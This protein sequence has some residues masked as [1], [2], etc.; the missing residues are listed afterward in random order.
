[1]N[2]IRLQRVILSTT[3]AIVMVAC[4][5]A[6]AKFTGADPVRARLNQL[7]SNQQLAQHAPIAM[8]E[9]RDAVQ[10]AEQSSK[11]Q[12]VAEHLIFMAERKVDIAEAE[13]EQH[14]LESR[15][16]E[17]LAQR[18][19]MQLQARTE[20]SRQATSEANQAKQQA[21]EAQRQ[22][23]EAQADAQLAQQQMNKAELDA[24]KA[25]EEV[26]EME[27]QL[28]ELNARNDERGTV[29][30]LGDVLFDFNKADINPAALSHLAKLATFLNSHEDRNAVIEGHTDNVGTDQVNLQLSQRRADAIKQYLQSQGVDGDR[31]DAVGK[32]SEFPVTENSTAQQR[33]QNRR[34]EVIINDTAG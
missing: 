14:Y 29:I 25:R 18:D 10:R 1:M 33:Q 20:E 11:D 13:S 5:S 6:P 23:G 28:E 30:T 31:L 7:E 8:K 19:S 26:A 22:A 34:V 24:V 12:A 9:A 32:G 27:R 17:L 3:I 15:R 2:I 21:M 4:A 16:N